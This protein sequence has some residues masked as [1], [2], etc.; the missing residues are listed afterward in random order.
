MAAPGE[1][2]VHGLNLRLLR[3]DD[4]LRQPAQHG[5]LAV[6]ELK[7]RHV[8][9]SLVVRNH[10]RGEVVVGVVRHRR[11]PHA[12]VHDG[13]AVVHLSR[14]LRLPAVSMPVPVPGEAR[15]R[16]APSVHGCARPP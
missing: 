5:V 2:E 7:P 1:L 10:H 6:G 3:D 16:L 11:R 13:H 14:E 12:L 4:F 9:G 15:F 8:D